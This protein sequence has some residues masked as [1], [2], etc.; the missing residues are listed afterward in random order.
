MSNTNIL[1]S[2][3]SYRDLVGVLMSVCDDVT[4]FCLMRT[5]KVFEDVPLDLRRMDI[6]HVALY[7][8]DVNNNDLWDYL[9]HGKL[10]PLEMYLIWLY[11][12]QNKCVAHSQL[13]NWLNNRIKCGIYPPALFSLASYCGD[14]FGEAVDIILRD[15]DVLN[16]KQ[17][18]IIEVLSLC[19]VIGLL[20][21]DV[22]IIECL[23]KIE[24][25]PLEL[26][27]ASVKAWYDD[28][29]IVRTPPVLF[30]P[31]MAAFAVTA[32]GVH[33]DLLHLVHSGRYLG[34]DVTMDEIMTI[35]GSRMYANNSC[36]CILRKILL[37]YC[38]H[39][40]NIIEGI[41]NGTFDNDE[42]E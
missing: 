16:I 11:S 18:Y 15:Y 31:T 17:T 27:C 3:A 7:C 13:S 42:I 26:I 2:I 32:S 5:S 38:P 20:Y 12:V 23:E 24:I 9:F 30:S 6:V 28:R 35:I 4:K 10:T 39:L 29:E 36:K 21:D 40:D 41:E 37:E 1:L 34:M 14:Q 8:N 19:S 33:P 25:A 22:K